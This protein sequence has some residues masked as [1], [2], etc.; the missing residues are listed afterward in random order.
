LT[1]ASDEG[2]IRSDSV[3]LCIS[4]V[5][6]PHTDTPIG[7]CAQ[8]PLERQ[9]SAHGQYR[10]SQDSHPLRTPPGVKHNRIR[11]IKSRCR[12]ICIIRLEPDLLSFSLWEIVFS[13]QDPSC[14]IV[15]TRPE[16]RA[17]RKRRVNRWTRPRSSGNRFIQEHRNS[18]CCDG[19]SSRGTLMFKLGKS[20]TGVPGIMVVQ[21]MSPVILRGVISLP[22]LSIGQL[23]D[24]ITVLHTRIRKFR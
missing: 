4:A 3:L 24:S 11:T 17:W 8:S 19:S 1:G 15:R 23:T 7:F 5:G 12:Q 13:T 9:A 18:G 21:S 6:E 20:L 16:S 22:L 2:G 10:T 14:M